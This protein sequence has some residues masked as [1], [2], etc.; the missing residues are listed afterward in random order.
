MVVQIDLY[1]LEGLLQDAANL[2]ATKALTDA[3]VLKPY[4]SKAEAYRI[5]SRRLIDRWLK[6]NLLIPEK[7]GDGGAKIRL[8]RVRLEV[9]ART[10]NRVSWFKNFRTDQFHK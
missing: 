6:E 4:L 10:S 3:G 7:D 9:L 2:G 8:S 1:K 5:Y